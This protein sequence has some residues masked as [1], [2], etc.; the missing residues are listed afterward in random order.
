MKDTYLYGEVHKSVIK[1]FGSNKKYE[2]NHSYC[3][4][5][6]PI[7]ELKFKRKNMHKSSR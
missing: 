5:D 2:V 7:E 4:P 6:K 1:N 3:F